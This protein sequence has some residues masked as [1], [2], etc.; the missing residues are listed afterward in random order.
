MHYY[1]HNNMSRYRD[2]QLAFRGIKK[3]KMQK[4][5]IYTNAQKENKTMNKAK[6]CSGKCKKA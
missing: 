4:K 6:S 5:Y 1:N 3:N 2:L